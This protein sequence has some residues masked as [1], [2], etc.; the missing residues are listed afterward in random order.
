MS[1]GN[2]IPDSK[3]SQENP[4]RPLRGSA[5]HSSMANTTVVYNY[6]DTT[7]RLPQCVANISSNSDIATQPELF[8]DGLPTLSCHHGV[9]AL[10][11]QYSTYVKK[12]ILYCKQRKINNI[13]AD[14]SD[15]LDFLT[16]LFDVHNLG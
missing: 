5:N 2:Q 14:L 13:H 8:Q 4:D 7:G 3:S 9:P 6:N 15:V 16:E 11:K 1:R 12:W 10:K